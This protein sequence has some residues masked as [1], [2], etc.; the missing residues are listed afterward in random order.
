MAIEQPEASQALGLWDET[1]LIQSRK[2]N[3]DLITGSLRWRTIRVHL[4]DF[5]FV[6]KEDNF[7]WI[8]STLFV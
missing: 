7:R 8:K 2:Y 3:L 1:K 5:E 6:M 4:K